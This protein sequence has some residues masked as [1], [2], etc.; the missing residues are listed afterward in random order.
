MK[1]STA[2]ANAKNKLEADEIH[3]AE[4]EAVWLMEFILRKKIT[5]FE[6]EITEKQK[7]D[8]FILI[9]KRLKRYPLQYLIGNVDFFNTEIRVTKDVLIPRPET[10]EM[11]ETAC[12]LLKNFHGEIICA[13]LGTGSGCI[14]I[15]IAKKLKKTKWYAVDA[16]ESA[17]SVA[18]ANAKRN[19]VEERIKFFHGS[20]FSV[21]PKNL[22]F[23]F[24]ITNPPYVEENEPLQPELAHEPASA[25]FSG[26]DGLDDYR[27]IISKLR[28]RLKPGGIF[29]GEFGFGQAGSLIKIAENH[30]FTNIEIL[31]DLS[32]R[33]RFIHFNKKGEHNVKRK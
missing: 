7:K 2:I 9:D 33:E 28:D 18:K 13:D 16:S 14:P 25:L 3:P 10:E 17:L 4:R 12:N 11:V 21:F 31:K 5:D 27:I 6:T 1:I 24:I 23:D 19:L 30:G 15:A 32:G 8:F 29:L 20:W 22:N 26:K